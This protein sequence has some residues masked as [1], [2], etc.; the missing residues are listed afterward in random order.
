MNEV[1]KEECSKASIPR[2]VTTAA[3]RLSAGVFGFSWH[4]KDVTVLGEKHA[5]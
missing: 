1:Y 5:S 4:L 3:V 2:T